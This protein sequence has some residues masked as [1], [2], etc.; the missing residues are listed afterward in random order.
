MS[1]FNGCHIKDPLCF[2]KYGAGERK[3]I[4]LVSEI[5]FSRLKRETHPKYLNRKTLNEKNLINTGL[6]CFT[7]DNLFVYHG[8]DYK[9]KP[10]LV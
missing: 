8:L 9:Q 1:K 10:L 5:G 7:N 6:D 3:A 2:R 4:L